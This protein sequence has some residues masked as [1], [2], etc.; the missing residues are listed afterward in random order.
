M[1]DDFVQNEQQQFVDRLLRNSEGLPETAFITSAG[2]KI[3]GFVAKVI[4]KYDYNH[5]NVRVVE[6][7]PAGTYPTVLGGQVVAV[8][9]AESFLSQ[10]TL[11]AGKYVIMFKIG[12]YYV[13]YAI[14]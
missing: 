14:P 6:L 9:V 1:A 5:Y 13:F 10:G 11:A 12:E 4:S 3:T 7:G 2:G 8:N